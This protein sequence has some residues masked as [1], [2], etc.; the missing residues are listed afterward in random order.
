MRTIEGEGERWMVKLRGS[1][2]NQGGPCIRFSLPRGVAVVASVGRW[3][4][5]GFRSLLKL[6][7]WFGLNFL[8]SGDG[9]EW[10][11]AE[12]SGGL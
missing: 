10:F 7:S 4:V 1:Q 11:R 6:T 9:H 8:N 2:F 12:G 5:C 3:S